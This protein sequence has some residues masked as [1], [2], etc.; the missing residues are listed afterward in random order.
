MLDKLTASP[1]F[2][3]VLTIA[4][5]QAGLWVSKQVKSR[6]CNSL[7]VAMA[8]VIGVLAVFR[9]PLERY[10]AGGSVIS[11]FLAPATAV[12]ALSIYRQLEV[13]RKNFLPVVA[14][15]LAGAV[16]S[17]VSA[18]GLCRAFGLDRALQMAMLP[19]SVTTP[20]AMEVAR[21]HG[22][23]VPV[24][25]A[26]VIVTGILGA[27]F[28]PVLIRLFRLDKCPVAQGVA[29]GSASHALG[30]TKAVEMGE[31]QGAMSGISIG[32]S[33]LVTVFLSLLVS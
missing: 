6:L 29:I 22:G 16:T 17:M 15:C 33:G 9:I 7:M 25:V 28:S 13:L 19:K 10:Q 2:G 11:L 30:T 8:L 18:V 12:L 14:G 20:I 27:I 26:A 4:A 23:L 3:I 24:T 21:Q 32:V 5:F 1:L 31:I